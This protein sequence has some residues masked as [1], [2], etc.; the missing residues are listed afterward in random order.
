[1]IKVLYFLLLFVCLL[2]I[3]HYIIVPIIENRLD[4]LGDYEY[5]ENSEK[6][7]FFWII[8]I[9]VAVAIKKAKEAKEAKER[10]ER[11]ARQARERAIKAAKDAEDRLVNEWT[12][13]LLLDFNLFMHVPAHIKHRLVDAIRNAMERKRLDDE[14]KENE[15]MIKAQQLIDKLLALAK[16]L[17][18]TKE[19][20]RGI[21]TSYEIKN[22]QQDKIV[23]SINEQLKKYPVD[24]DEVRTLL[25]MLR[26]YN[27]RQYRK[28]EKRK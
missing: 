23:A 19:Q 8:A 28:T 5:E 2:W 1:M 27:Y 22:I 9:G 4:K 3:F 26:E 11:E 17:P 6:E 15:R 25:N 10:R 18:R 20:I 14:R 12:R 24:V 7:G 16:E 13:K 21:I